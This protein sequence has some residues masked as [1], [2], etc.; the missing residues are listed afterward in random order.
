MEENTKING[1]QDIPSDDLSQFHDM[2][3]TQQLESELS[4]E[5][6]RSN[7]TH[8]LQNAVNTL[9]TVSAVA[10]LVATLW[11]PVLR[12]YGSSMFPTLREGNLVVSLKGSD[13]KTGDV[14][15]FYYNNK[16]LVKR[17]MAT[18]GD[19]VDLDLQGNVYINNAKLNEPYIDE[20]AYGECD[21][22]LP[23]QV[24]EGRIFV[25]GD[26]RSVSVDSR[27]TTV[28]CVSEEQIVGKMVF[29]I[30]PVSDFGPIV[31]HPFEMR[32]NQ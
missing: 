14:I 8:F 21:I 5:R 24:P 11:L 27:S 13:F 29:C 7:F 17:V 18:R 22:E 25:M 2:P 28:G 26:N 4:R 9:L 3:S 10:I 1:L 15:A 20:L 31:R 12:I 16:I 6:Y 23:Y 19:W 32:E 30:W